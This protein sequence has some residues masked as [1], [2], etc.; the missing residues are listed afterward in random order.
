MSLTTV[1]INVS[2]HNQ[3]GTSFY[4]LLVPLMSSTLCA[5]CLEDR[6]FFNCDISTQTPFLCLRIASYAC[7]CTTVYSMCQQ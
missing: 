5:Y 4:F 2:L 7:T 1:F 6:Y 3:Y